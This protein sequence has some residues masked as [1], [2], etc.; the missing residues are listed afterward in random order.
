MVPQ[1]FLEHHPRGRNWAASCKA[2]EWDEMNQ[3]PGGTVPAGS[4]TAEWGC[5]HLLPRSAGL[6]SLG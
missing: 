3:S 6:S 5:T 4:I 1:D 2:L